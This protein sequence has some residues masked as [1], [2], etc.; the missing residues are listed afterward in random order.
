M[1]Q[2][3]LILPEDSSVINSFSVIKHN[4][5]ELHAALWYVFLATFDATTEFVVHKTKSLVDIIHGGFGTLCMQ[6][7]NFYL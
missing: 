1:M 5:V 3:L 6:H 4:C 7:Q 2:I